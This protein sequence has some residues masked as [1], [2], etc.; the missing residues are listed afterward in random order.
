MWSAKSCIFLLEPLFTKALPTSGHKI[1]MTK[2]E[3]YSR[4]PLTL[5]GRERTSLILSSAIR[6]C[7]YAESAL[8]T[9]M[10]CTIRDGER[11]DGRGHNFQLKWAA[12]WL[13]FGRAAVLESVPKLADVSPKVMTSHTLTTFSPTYV[14][15]IMFSRAARLFEHHHTRCVRIHWGV[16]VC[17]QTAVRINAHDVIATL[18]AT[19]D[20]V[21]LEAWCESEFGH[22]FTNCWYEISKG[23]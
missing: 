11:K 20:A 14:R 10:V 8:T 12:G 15:A 4:R 9:L 1:S 19:T 22:P 7:V 5:G 23:L 3:Q 6:R 13:G 18:G 2:V 16:Y 17:F 21:L